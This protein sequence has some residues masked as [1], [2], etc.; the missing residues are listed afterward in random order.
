[1]DILAKVTNKDKKKHLHNSRKGNILH[2]RIQ[3]R[4]TS[5]SDKLK[6]TFSYSYL[7]LPSILPT[8][9]S[10][11]VSKQERKQWSSFILVVGWLVGFTM[12]NN[13]DF[14]FLLILIASH[15]ENKRN[16]S[17]AAKKF[18]RPLRL[19]DTCLTIALVVF[20]SQSVP[21]ACRDEEP[22]RRYSLPTTQL[23]CGIRSCVFQCGLCVTNMTSI[24]RQFW[25]SC[26]T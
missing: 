9:F 16:V 19:S 15:L 25:S 24:G 5:T 3:P 10:L 8:P 12:N 18:S 21:L 20:A 26:A 22:P 7:W 2:S 1:M 4:S 14:A 17:I 6:S 13:G 11:S 23:A